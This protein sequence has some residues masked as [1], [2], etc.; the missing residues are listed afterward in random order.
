MSAPGVWESGDRERGGGQ[1]QVRGDDAGRV[2]QY[3]I[4]F[5]DSLTRVKTRD[6]PVRTCVTWICWGTYSHIIKAYMARGPAL[7]GQWSLCAE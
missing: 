5:K 4:K 7:P 6:N 3:F 2:G 1:T